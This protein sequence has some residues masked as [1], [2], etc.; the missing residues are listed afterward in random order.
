MVGQEDADAV[1]RADAG[2]EGLDPRA[3][4]C[5]DAHAML[6][7]HR[8]GGIVLRQL[9]LAA[10]DVELAVAASSARSCWWRWIE[11]WRSSDRLSGM[12]A[13]RIGS[14]ARRNESSQGIAR[15]Q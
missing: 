5:L 10:I 1:V 4:E 2:F 12:P 3:V 7:P 6:P 11:G 9:R 15:P 13:T 14:A 8:P